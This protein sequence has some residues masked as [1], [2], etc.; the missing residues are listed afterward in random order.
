MLSVFYKI[1]TTII[2]DD[3]IWNE[4]IA[5]FMFIHVDCSLPI[6]VR[7]WGRRIKRGDKSEYDTGYTQYALLERRQSN[8]YQPPGI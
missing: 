4:E 7:R 1:L 2:T 8:K 3:E 5:E 6:R